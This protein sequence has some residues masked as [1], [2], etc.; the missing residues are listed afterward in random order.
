MLAVIYLRPFIGESAQLATQFERRHTV[1]GPK[2]VVRFQARRLEI[3]VRGCAGTPLG[4]QRVRPTRVRAGRQRFA[5]ILYAALVDA[6][7]DGVRR[8]RQKSLS[9][10][11]LLSFRFDHI[12]FLCV[13]HRPVRLVT[14][15][16]LNCLQCDKFTFRILYEL[17]WKEKRKMLVEMTNME[18]M[19]QSHRFGFLVIYHSLIGFPYHDDTWE[20]AAVVRWTCHRYLTYIRLYRSQ[21]SENS[22][23][24]LFESVTQSVTCARGGNMAR[25]SDATNALAEWYQTSA[26]AHM[27]F[28]PAMKRPTTRL[29]LSHCFPTSGLVCEVLRHE[30]ASL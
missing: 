12:M 18:W 16:R 21:R 9:A 19:R 2:F 24:S 7:I 29:T 17:R 20:W 13:D 26:D 23:N 10:R 3:G 1:S 22:W 4:H 5:A 15:V 8:A 14:F 25:A 6:G 11:R 30:C 27:R 28:M